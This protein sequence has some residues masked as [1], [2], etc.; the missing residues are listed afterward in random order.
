MA[1]D[2]EMLVTRRGTL[3]LAGAALAAVIG[4]AGAQG[5]AAAPF[6]HETVVA[7]ARELASQ[8]YVPPDRSL[9]APLAGLSYDDY[10]RINFRRES[11]LLR[12]AGS[13]FGLQ[14]F[15][16]G[17]IFHKRVKVNLVTDGVAAP[18]A[19][20]PEMFDFGG[21]APPAGLP[22]TLGFA[23]LRLLYPLNN[24]SDLDELAAFLGS[25]YFRFLGKGQRYGLSA[26][27]ISIGSGAPHEEFPDFV[28]F[29]VVPPATGGG[30]I[31]VHALLDGPS[32]TGAYRFVFA[33]GKADEVEVQ[34]T[35]F[36]RKDL[37][38]LGIAPLTSMFLHGENTLA[39]PRDFRPEVHDSD[40]LA[41]RTIGGE[42]IWRALRNPNKTFVSD[43]HDTDT[44]G[45]GL[46]QRDRDF[47]HYQ[48]LEARY[49][50]RPG[51]WVEMKTRLG[52]GRVAL[53]EIHSG[54][55]TDDNIVAS[56]VPDEQPLAGSETTV[57]YV[58][59]SVGGLLHD[60]GYVVA[61][62]ETHAASAGAAEKAG[63]TRFLVDFAGGRL[64]S[65]ALTA[66][67]LELV[68]TSSKGGISAQTV[69]HNPAIGGFR[70][71][72]DVALPPGEDI[73]LRAFVKLGEH[74]VTE[75]WSY[76]R[77]AD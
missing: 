67:N 34:A 20:T 33:P 68:A 19:Y 45:F 41:M 43:L 69:V 29:W 74:V 23:G 63:T 4:P 15:H 73:D 46:L 11:T 52:Q 9:P 65:I 51:Y 24:S 75:T 62:F 57:A 56:W 22:D 6:G 54:A 76:R 12:S 71:S 60:G 17:G 32:I 21:G 37:V 2:P 70:A 25:S 66:E 39:K 50:L 1:K 77:E 55:E 27:G 38:G 8:A 40:G 49:D 14:L 42:W 35:L 28:E 7:I 64:G 13:D 5:P 61:S 18:L 72:F 16:R 31:T 58:I 44:S 30:S 48:D 10:R 47:S 59:R 53:A 26:R 36:A 3:L